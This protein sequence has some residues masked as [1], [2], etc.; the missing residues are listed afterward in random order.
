MHAPFDESPYGIAKRLAIVGAW[1]EDLAR[2]A[3]R[4]LEILDVGCGTGEQLTVPLAARGYR[5]LG[6]DFHEP[7]IVRARTLHSLPGL[8]FEVGDIHSVHQS[9]RRFDVVI[10]SEVLEHVRDPLAFVTA[11]RALLAPGGALIVTTPNGYG[12]YEWLAGLERLL[13][14]TGVHGALRAAFWSTRRAAAAL[15]GRKGPS[16]PLENLTSPTD[17]GFLNIDSG[18][19]QF[20]TVARLEGLFRDA[21]LEIVERRARTLLCGPYID[22]VFALLPDRARWYRW[23]NAAADRLPFAAAADWM[24]LLRPTR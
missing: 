18:H 8:A 24:F 20:F 6:V 12:A 17:T 14:R 21:G 19:V 22:A 13:R 1:L 9:G 2:K 10:C 5:V 23:N 4:T 7:T 15:R 11:G 3:S 16:R